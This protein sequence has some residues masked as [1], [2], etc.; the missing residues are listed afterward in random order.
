MT[1]TTA[2]TEVAYVANSYA[3]TLSVIDVEARAVVETIAMDFG[4]PHPVE[5]WPEGELQLANTP[6]NPKFTPDGSQLYVPNPEGHNLA[7]VDVATN[8][9]VEVVELA[10]KPCDIEFTPD[11]SRA[12]VSLLGRVTGKQG[13]LTVLDVPAHTTLEPV[14][15]GTQ[16][17]ELVLTADGKRA[18][19]VSKSLWVID[20][21]ANE[22]EKEI[23]LPEHCYDAVLSPDG[24]HLYLTATF[25]GAKL[26]VVDTTTNMVSGSIDV[27][28][29]ACM[30]FT[31]DPNRLLVSNVYDGSMQSVDLRT[32]AV[33]EPVR[34]GELPSYIALTL[35]G[36]RAFVCHPANDYVTV[37]DTT[38]LEALD[39][40][41]V[42]LGP[43]ALA[44][45]V[46]P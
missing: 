27:L 41:Q 42:D 2:G 17:E 32:E 34:I 33:S 4:D 45:G 11:G 10:M 30:A 20:V 22:V 6:M 38:T 28:M 12:V 31:R 13:A 8:E 1:V 37:I 3:D 19:I 9:I 39:R 24:K 36:A 43:C 35:D 7:V 5:R 23:H 26:V 44:I 15:V 25:G 46:R 21:D 29:P 16:P 18:Y 14:M 40:I